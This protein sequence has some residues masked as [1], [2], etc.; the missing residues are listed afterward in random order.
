[1]EVAQRT[2]TQKNSHGSVP[3]EIDINSILRRTRRGGGGMGA[4]LEKC[5][6]CF[7]YRNAMEIG[8]LYLKEKAR[9]VG[10]EPVRAPP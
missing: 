9:V 3:P 5:R 8:N 7:L 10:G 1:M 4:V 2:T 6:R